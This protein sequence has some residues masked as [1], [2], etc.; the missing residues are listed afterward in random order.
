MSNKDPRTKSPA[1]SSKSGLKDR[2]DV[3]LTFLKKANEIYSTLSSPCRSEQGEKCGRTASDNDNDLQFIESGTPATTTDNNN[4]ISP[5]GSKYVN[6]QSNNK[7]DHTINNKEEKYTFDITNYALSYAV[8]QSLP[9]IKF[10]CEP[11]VNDQ[12][13]GANII[14]ELFKVIY[15]DFKQ[16][17]PKH[18]NIIGFE[19]WFINSEGNICG[20]TRDINL[21]MYLCDAKKIPSRLLNKNITPILP[22][23][24]PPQCSVVIKGV[25]N[26][27]SIDEF[28]RKID[29]KYNS[30]YSVEELGDTNSGRWRHLRIDLLNKIE[31]KQLLNAG[32]ICKHLS[33]DLSCPAIR[34]YRREV[35]KH[36][37]LHPEIL[38]DHVQTFIP[39]YCRLNG[40]KVLGDQRSYFHSQQQQQYMNL[41]QNHPDV[42][43]DWPSLPPPISNTTSAYL[44]P[45][46]QFHNR[47]DQIEGIQI[48]M[49][50][51]ECEFRNAKNEF[52]RKN[53]HI[54]TKFNNSI[55]QIQSLIIC[56]TTVI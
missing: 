37:Q 17:Y 36:I 12:H 10:V 28:K 7:Q 14:K 16:I 18:N 42:N 30:I 11:G 54:T 50:K 48:R 8:N 33:T 52:D 20:I 55:A 45:Q 5:T 56:F 26:T 41:N 21:Y 38:P 19:A 34:S 46:H 3:E 35:I 51:L 2:R 29:D 22:K 53:I 1:Q 15:D 31:Y 43:R 27:I 23:H 6:N 9:F 25:S 44:K 13:E 4:L 40:G 39:S 32:V 47:S 24:L 49:N